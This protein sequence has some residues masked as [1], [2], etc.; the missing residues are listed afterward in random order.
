MHSKLTY[1]LLLFL[2]TGNAMSAEPKRANLSKWFG[3]PPPPDTRYSEAQLRASWERVEENLSQ[4]QP[5]MS[6]AEVLK[7]LGNPDWKIDTRG[8]TVWVSPKD[9]VLQYTRLF[10]DHSSSK[11][12][13]RHI[14]IFFDADAKVE[15]VLKNGPSI[16]ASPPR[17]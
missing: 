4:V 14:H 3:S 9:G 2:L 6:I 7:K 15:K 11:G 16:F 8:R 1:W 12:F 17:E 13:L 10:G 5:G